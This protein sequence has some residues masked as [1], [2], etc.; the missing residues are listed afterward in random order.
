MVCKHLLVLLVLP[1][2]LHAVAADSNPLT[3]E[4]G[5]KLYERCKTAID[6]LRG[7]TRM[8]SDE[9]FIASTTCISYIDGFRE[10]HNVTAGL[11]A[12]RSKGAA[13]TEHD[14]VT[15]SLYCDGRAVSNG[16]VAQA[17]VGYLEKYPEKRRSRPGVVLVEVLRSLTPCR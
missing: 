12:G 6:V 10:G 9:K 16:D 4:T 1:A 15:F 7:T 8:D 13:V 17:V 2:T 3:I 11:L 5:T 14:I